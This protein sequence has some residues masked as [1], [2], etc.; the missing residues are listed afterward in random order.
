[1]PT[2]EPSTPPIPPPG[3]GSAE[4]PRTPARPAPPTASGPPD[5]QV[6]IPR[7]GAALA[8][9]CAAVLLVQAMVAGINLALPSLAASDLRP[10]R[11][12]LVWI[13]DVYVVVFAGLLIPAGALGD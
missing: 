7:A 5:A 12:S 8:S 9:L 1:M 3:S 2:Q 13:V 10:S 6:G 11:T 4:A